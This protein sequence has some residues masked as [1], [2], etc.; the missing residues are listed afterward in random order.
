MH[1]LCMAIVVH[2]NYV[3][4]CHK[5]IAA[6]LLQL[7]GLLHT[8]KKTASSIN[9]CPHS[10]CNVHFHPAMCRHGE[11]RLTGGRTEYEGRVEMCNS[12]SQ[13]GTVCNQQWTDTHSKV[14]CSSLGH[15][16]EEGTSF[17]SIIGCLWAL[18]AECM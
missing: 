13:W 1:T 2:N 6:T 4:C 12:H 8:L 5:L 10:H 17:S 7:C 9:I 16:D 14:V 15:S 18:P 11:T 3:F